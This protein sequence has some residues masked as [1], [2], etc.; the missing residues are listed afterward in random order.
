MIRH[1]GIASLGTFLVLV[2][3]TKSPDRAIEAVLNDCAACSVKVNQSTMTAEQSARYLADQMQA[4]DVRDCPADFRVAFQD[5]IM[6]WRVA[7]AHL[8]ANTTLNTML[9]AIAAGFF[10]DAS[11]LNASQRNAYLALQ[12]I[13]VTYRRLSLIASAYG[14]RIPVSVVE[15]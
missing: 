8:D 12:E 15:K 13:N 10:D 2:G 14:A 5:H 11:L 6:A 4:M 1:L 7:G 3:C 9:E